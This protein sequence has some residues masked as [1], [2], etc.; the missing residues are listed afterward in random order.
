MEERRCSQKTEL[1]TDMKDFTSGAH[2]SSAGERELLYICWEE[3]NEPPALFIRSWID[4]LH[5]ARVYSIGG[6]EICKRDA[7]VPPFPPQQPS[8]SFNP[9]LLLPHTPAPT[10]SID[11]Q[12]IR[13]RLCATAAQRTDAAGSKMAAA[14]ANLMPE[15]GLWLQAHTSFVLAP[16]ACLWF[17]FQCIH[18]R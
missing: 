8:T 10:R 12:L 4:W 18:R 3:I 7:A 9:L 1:K 16:G 13:R 11:E 6:R 2:S 15:A 14:S 5:G 17:F